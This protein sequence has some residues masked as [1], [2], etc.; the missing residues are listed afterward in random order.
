MRAS[1]GALVAIAGGDLGSGVVATIVRDGAE[2]VLTNPATGSAPVGSEISLTSTTVPAGYLVENG[3]CVSQTT[4]AAL[5]AYYGGSDIWSPGSTGSACSAGNF[6]LPYANGR[7]SVAADTMGGVVASVLTSGGSSCLATAPAV[8]CGAQNRA[9]AQAN[10]PNVNF[11]HSGTTLSDPGHVH[12]ITDPGHAH[13]AG[14]GDGFI[15]YFLGNTGNIG[16]NPSGTF[17][18]GGSVTAP[19]TTGISINSATTGITVA[20]QGSAASGGSGAALP[21]VQPTYTVYRAVKY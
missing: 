16:Y 10:L 4:Y 19:N 6:H 1:G 5:Y 9:I 21:T 17:F 8:L 20:S 12:S 13:G 11:T 18:G 7:T 3:T 14:V 2:F 15:N